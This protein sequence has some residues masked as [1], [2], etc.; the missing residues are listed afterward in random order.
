MAVGNSTPLLGYD[1]YVAIG[2]ETTF[3]TLVTATGFTEFNSEA[4]NKEREE[5]RLESINTTRDYRKR[6]TGNETIAGSL[7]IDLNIWEDSNLWMIKQAMGGTVA[8]AAVSA[9]S[10][11]HTFNVGNMESNE[12]TAGSADVKSLTMQIRRGNTDQWSYRGMRINTMT[13]KGEVGTPVT[14]TFELMGMAGTTS[15]DSITASFASNVPL[16]FTGVE[17][18][19]G[20]T[21]SAVST[22]Y[23]AGFELTLENNIEE[24]RNLGTAYPYAL[25]ATRRNVM[26]KL[27]QQFDTTTSYDRYIQ[28]TMTAIQINMDTGITI[29]GSGGTTA[30]MQINLPVCY[31]NSNTPQ[32]SEMGP[33]QQEVEVSTLLNTSTNYV[34]NIIV[35]NETAN[36]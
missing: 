22:E 14:A 25:P 33:V 27:T 30:S 28:N 34:M 3:G 11:L 5:L 6:L 4:I 2:E 19:T 20:I 36:Y 15:S 10:Y 18:K 1:S 13:I 21:I 29:S 9:T 24:Q 16:H 12:S 8:T 7:E 17:F 35:A 23:I 32:I 31:F 26:L